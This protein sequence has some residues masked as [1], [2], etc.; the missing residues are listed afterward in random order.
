MSQ[1]QTDVRKYIRIARR[2]KGP[3][4]PFS[5][6]NR[7]YDTRLP[8]DKQDAL[9]NKFARSVTAAKKRDGFPITGPLFNVLKALT[10]ETSAVVDTSSSVKRAFIPDPSMSLKPPSSRSLTKKI[11]LSTERNTP[12]NFETSAAPSSAQM[13][14]IKL[15]EVSA[16]EPPYTV[17]EFKNDLKDWLKYN[18]TSKLNGATQ[19]VYF[20][21]NTKITDFEHYAAKLTKQT[22][23]ILETG[24]V[25]KMRSNKKRELYGLDKK[26]AANIIGLV[27]SGTKGPFFLT[28][29]CPQGHES[30]EC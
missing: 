22:G 11:K 18:Q 26:E 29:A 27:K 9:Y 3:I 13:K 24:G 7:K 19:V 2:I 28:M 20:V 5:E 4:L 14:K 10:K 12:T 25:F 21:P 23:E 15:S 17:D 30:C 1:I 16:A 6:F 8:E